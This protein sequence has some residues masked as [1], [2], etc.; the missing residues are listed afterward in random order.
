MSPGL[1]DPP[2]SQ[3]VWSLI[4]IDATTGNVIDAIP[5]TEPGMYN[6]YY[7]GG[8]Y[9]DAICKS[10]MIHMFQRTLDNVVEGLIIDM[11][12]GSI[13]WSFMPNLGVN[14]ANSLVSPVAVCK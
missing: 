9:G 1:V 12:D 7:G 4:Q 3:R 5:V 8:V 13:I 14:N 10:Q 11:D 6:D 2:A